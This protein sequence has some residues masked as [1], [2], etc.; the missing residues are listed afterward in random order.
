M[1]HLRPLYKYFLGGFLAAFLLLNLTQ[2]P[3]DTAKPKD[4]EPLEETAELTEFSNEVINAFANS[5]T[6]QVSD[7]MY[8]EHREFYI[9][10]LQDNTD[11]MPTFAEALKERKL[12]GLNHLYAEYEITID[13][14]VY[15]IAYGQ[16]GD[17]VWKILR[18]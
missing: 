5:S 14:A 13:G 6:D 7:M 16:S 8:E 4:E 1:T 11:K 2:C 17:G 18:F 12:I 10:D 3:E 15:T 9:P